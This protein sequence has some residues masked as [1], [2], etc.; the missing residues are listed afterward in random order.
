M[1]EKWELLCVDQQYISI[2]SPNISSKVTIED[3]VL[4]KGGDIK[5]LKM[6]RN[7]GSEKFLEKFAESISSTFP[8]I[9]ADG[10]EPLRIE[11]RSATFRRKLE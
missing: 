10:W 9:L 3:F 6:F 7:T 2:F 1:N 4:E 5:R 8:F 11:M